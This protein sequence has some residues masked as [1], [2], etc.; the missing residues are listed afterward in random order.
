MRHSATHK[1]YRIYKT[2]WHLTATFIFIIAPIV[3]L[4]LFSRFSGIAASHLLADTAAS[5]WRLAAAYL[6]AAILGWCLAVSFYRG[7][8]AA[9]ALPA[10]DVLQSFPTFAALPLAMHLWG[11]SD[12]TV[13]FFL[14]ITI[15]WPILFSVVSALKLI[16]RDWQEAVMVANL[17][18]FDYVRYFIIPVSLPGFITGTIIGLGEGW[19]ALVAT[20][21]IVGLKNGLGSFFTTFVDNTTITVLGI[22]GFLLLIFSFN[23]LIWLPLLEWSHR[24][25]SE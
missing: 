12:F 18:G 15:I 3:F 19:E 4:F 7:K 10:F 25:M 6:I 11:N 5:L 24:K 14:V 23:K 13:I 17:R 1:T 2:R 9:A 21:I 22:F 8:L 16:R 20:E